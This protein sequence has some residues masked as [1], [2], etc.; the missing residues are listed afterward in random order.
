MFSSVSFLSNAFTR[1]F[2]LCVEIEESVSRGL[3]QNLLTI[4]LTVAGAKQFINVYTS[5]LGFKE[6][7]DVSA[8]GHTVSF[9]RIVKLHVGLLLQSQV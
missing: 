5:L 8:R 1:A 7:S 6:S 2:E 9:C 3:W 4:T